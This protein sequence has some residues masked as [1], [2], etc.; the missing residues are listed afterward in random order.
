MAN[1]KIRTFGEFIK[2]LREASGCPQRKIA[3]ELD[4]DPSL[5]GKIERDE[6]PPTKVIIKKLAAIF[7]QDEDY[8]FEEHLSDQIANKVLEGRGRM[9]VLK[10]AREKIIYLKNKKNAGNSY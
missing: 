3:A 9:E 10:V 7:K 2:E 5:L 8:L 1:K 6:R 4:I